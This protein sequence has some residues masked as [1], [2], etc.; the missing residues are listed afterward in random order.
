MAARLNKDAKNGPAP[1]EGGRPPTPIDL[2]IV[3]RAAG[4]GA[5][6]DEIAAL[7]GVPRRTLYDRM[8]QDPEIQQA[9]DEGRDQGRITLRRLQWQQAEAGNPTM[10][11]WLGK[12]LLG[13]RDRHEV[14]QTGTGAG[15]QNLVLLHLEAARTVS[16]EILAAMEQPRTITGHADPANGQAKPVTGVDLLSAPPPLE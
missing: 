14:E 10:L 11:I 7:L 6:V 2:A 8:E 13:Q 3:R 12:Q 9:L 4:L 15:T 5:T 1:G 16:T